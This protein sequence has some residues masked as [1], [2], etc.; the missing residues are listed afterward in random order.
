[1]NYE[2]NPKNKILDAAKKLFVTKG[3]QA[4]TIREIAN[5]AKVNSALIQ[6]HFKGKQ[7]LLVTIASEVLEE[8]FEYFSDILDG[9]IQ[10]KDEF[11]IKLSMFLD[12]TITRGLA[13][14]SS[15]KILINESYEL[16]QIK[17]FP[18][19]NLSETFLKYLEQFLSKAKKKGIISKEINLTI[20][21]DTL[22]SLM[23]DQVLNWK[24]NKEFGGHDIFDKATRKLWLSHTL[25]IFFN[26]ILTNHDKKLK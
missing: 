12:L 17:S 23:L 25:T 7:G 8:E 10:T 16:S 14:Y 21:A 26:G 1:M 18:Y 20:L 2:Q 3:Y 4:T 13:K 24:V 11:K 19:R 5:E 9:D 6:Y 15:I 22:L